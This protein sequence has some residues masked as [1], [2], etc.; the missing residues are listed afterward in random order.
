MEERKNVTLVKASIKRKK[1]HSDN[2]KYSGLGP[3]RRFYAGHGLRQNCRFLG[4]RRGRLERWGKKQ[5]IT[6][7]ALPLA[8]R[9][10]FRRKFTSLIL[11]FYMFK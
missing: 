7:S 6:I 5:G 9:V 4:R 8:S 1:S 11:S 10:V 2:I 3:I